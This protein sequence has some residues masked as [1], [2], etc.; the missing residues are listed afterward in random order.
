MWWLLWPRASRWSKARDQSAPPA[1]QE[2]ADLAAQR[3]RPAGILR[4]TEGLFLAT[5]TPRWARK[6]RA[7]IIFACLI[8]APDKFLAA[9]A[10]SCSNGQFKCAGDFS[11]AGFGLCGFSLSL[12]RALSDRPRRPRTKADRLKPVL[13]SAS[14]ILICAF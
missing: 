5:A 11:S 8:P 6:G 3:R 13:L 12:L 1:R 14:I 7:R 2:S 10:M 4:S 9:S